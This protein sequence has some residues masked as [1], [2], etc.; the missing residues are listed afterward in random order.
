MSYNRCQ[1]RENVHPVPRAGIHAPGD[2]RGENA[3]KHSPGAKRGKYMHS[4]LS[5]VQLAYG[6]SSLLVKNSTLSTLWKYCWTLHRA[7]LRPARSC[8]TRVGPATI[9]K[10]F[11]LFFNQRTEPVRS[12]LQYA[13]NKRCQMK[14]PPPPLNW[15]FPPCWRY[16]PSSGSLLVR[17]PSL[18]VVS[19]VTSSNHSRNIFKWRALPSNVRWVDKTQYNLP[20]PAQTLQTRFYR[21]LTT[22]SR[23]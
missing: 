12:L 21:W 6:F 16:K 15:V 22:P 19:I 20:S 18:N 8:V 17:S 13:L 11:A 4:V 3:G 1:S 14:L 9:N 10:R 7:Q 23:D 2:K 5:G